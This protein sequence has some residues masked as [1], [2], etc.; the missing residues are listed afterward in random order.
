MVAGGAVKVLG[1]LSCTS[2]DT[3]E[4]RGGTTGAI[5]AKVAVGGTKAGTEAVIEMVVAGTTGANGCPPATS[6]SRRI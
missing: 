5:G 4:P 2:I 3:F 1:E 6:R